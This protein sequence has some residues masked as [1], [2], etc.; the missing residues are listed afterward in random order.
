MLP[1]AIPTD[2]DKYFF[3]RSDEIAKIMKYVTSI[4]NNL[5]SQVLVLGGKG[6]GKTFFVKKVLHDLNDDIL[7]IFVDLSNIYGVNREIKEEEILKEILSKLNEHLTGDGRLNRLKSMI[8]SG[9]QNLAVNKYDLTESVDLFNMSVPKIKKDYSKLSRL[10]MDLLQ[11]IVDTADEISGVVIAFDEFQLIDEL[12]NPDAFLMLIRSSMKNQQN[13]CYI[14]TGNFTSFSD[15]SKIIKSGFGGRMP[16]FY[17]KPFTIEDTIAYIEKYASDLRFTDDGYERFYEYTLGVPS[18]INSFAN[19]LRSDVVY[20]RAKIDETYIENID[21]IASVWITIWMRF[22]SKQKEIIT[23]L[24]DK[25]S[26]SFDDMMG[27]TNLSEEDLKNTLY[28]MFDM[29]VVFED[30]EYSFDN[31]MIKMWLLNEKKTKGFYPP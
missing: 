1:V 3:N 6:V 31:E 5:A 26:A 28:N 20:D 19:V 21:R 12:E 11:N 14:Y 27:E 29:D 4:H 23:L 22:S 13:V 30:G 24:I 8:E 17:L 16:H 9:I 10:V 2:I 7:T 15:V 18:Y 25:G